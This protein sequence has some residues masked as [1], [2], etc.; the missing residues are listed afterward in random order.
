MHRCR[1]LVPIRSHIEHPREWPLG[2]LSQRRSNS[3]ASTADRN[4]D[5]ERARSLR[6]RFAHP[7]KWAQ[8]L[9]SQSPLNSNA[10]TAAGEGVWNRA[11]SLRVPTYMVWGADTDVGKTLISAGLAHSSAASQVIGANL[12]AIPYSC[13]MIVGFLWVTCLR[14]LTQEFRLRFTEAQD[15]GTGY[16][17]WSTSLMLL[18]KCVPHVESFAVL[19]Q[20]RQAAVSLHKSS[21]SNRQPL[22][23]PM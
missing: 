22:Q 9:V 20:E 3:S 2:Y 6:S 4:N 23:A 11:R 10:P 12:R 13:C 5:F 19:W 7:G 16:Q 18:S 1:R 15:T 8:D 14:L 21:N 17:T